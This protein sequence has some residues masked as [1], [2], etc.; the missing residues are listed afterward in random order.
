MI[1]SWSPSWVGG[2]RIVFLGSPRDAR[3][4]GSDLY[5]I[6]ADGDAL[7]VFAGRP[8]LDIV[9]AVGHFAPA[10]SLDGAWVA[11]QS[12]RSGTLDLYVARTDGS[13]LR[14]ISSG[15]DGT[16]GIP[17]WSPDAS[18]LAY[19]AMLEGRGGL[20]ITRIGDGATAYLTTGALAV[21]AT[22]RPGVT[23]R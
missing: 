20:W 3:S 9:L 23:T 13:A 15:A 8:A 17:A 22:R 1:E 12:E 4:G 11:F 6:G 16:A 10:V 14:Q 5:T 19:H 18:H 7:A 2:E 21:V